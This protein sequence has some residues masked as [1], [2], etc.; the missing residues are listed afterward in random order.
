MAGILSPN[1][2]LISALST[3]MLSFIFSRT[4]VAHCAVAGRAL[5]GLS[6]A[7]PPAVIPLGQ[8]TGQRNLLRMAG[9]EAASTDPLAVIQVI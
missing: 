7:G 3:I 2:S 1:Q 6:F 9:G 4:T 5:R 8:R